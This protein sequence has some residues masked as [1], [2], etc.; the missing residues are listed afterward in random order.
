MT[1]RVA[2]LTAGQIPDRSRAELEAAFE[3]HAL[4]EDAAERDALLAADGARL[5]G[6]AVRGARNLPC[7]DVPGKRAPTPE[8]CHGGPYVPKG[9]L[10][11]STDGSGQPDKQ[12]LAGARVN[13]CVDEVL[14]RTLDIYTS[15][16]F[17]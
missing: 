17:A 16:V 2:V 11:S 13:K 6:I 4:P 14:D 12:G 9:P 1:A 7:M 3:V 5:R 15:P 10:P 8:V